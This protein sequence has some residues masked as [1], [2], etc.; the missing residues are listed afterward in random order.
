VAP[1]TCHGAD[2]RV[3]V[4]MI[5]RDR[6]DSAVRTVRRLR[7]LPERP[8]VIVVDNGSAD[9]TAAALRGM[10]GVTVAA[11]RDNLG[12]A[13]RTVGVTMAAT[14]YVAF[15]DDDS[16]WAPGA[17]ARAAELFDRHPRLALLV[18]RTLVGPEE[19][20]DPVNALLAAAPFGRPADLPGPTAAGFL[21][22]AAVVRQEPFLA[23]GGFHRRYGVG[24][25]ERLL[26][27]DLLRRGC[28]VAYVPAVVAH[29]HP[30]PGPERA[31]RRVRQARN[32]LWTVWLRRRWPT[33]LAATVRAARTADGR[34]ALRAALPGLPWIARER[35]P[36]DRALEALL[37]AGD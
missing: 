37:R 19:R 30:A 23:A 4:V 32:D 7:A 11:S 27:L 5:T 1:L 25:E 9:G 20:E 24:G 36:V 34:A 14:P 26:A 2:G 21:A 33:V 15:A 8:P 17:L 28:G 22:C 3:A 12:S 6:R 13:G 10:D 18:A 16:W 31:G 29:H 35:A